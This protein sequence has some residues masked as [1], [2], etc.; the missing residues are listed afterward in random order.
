MPASGAVSG[1][2]GRDPSQGRAPRRA[3]RGGE[4]SLFFGLLAVHP[5]PAG[6]HCH[7]NGGARPAA[8]RDAPHQP[9]TRGARDPSGERQDGSDAAGL[10]GRASPPSSIRQSLQEVVGNEEFAA[11][12]GPK[13]AEVT[14]RVTQLRGVPALGLRHSDK[15]VHHQRAPRVAGRGVSLSR[16]SPS[17]PPGG[18]RPATR[19]T[20]LPAPAP[21]SILP[22]EALAPPGRL[23]PRPVTHNR[24]RWWRAGR[25]V[26]PGPAAPRRREAAGSRPRRCSDRPGTS[27]R[28]AHPPG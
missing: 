24:E 3:A 20:P 19:P 7:G 26:A 9:G 10:H 14:V 4:R 27:A 15:A 11:I 1:N 2:H 16:R 18:P 13:T 8:D 21:C 17:A 25:V 23:W 12:I 28:C 5:A 6:C 22:D